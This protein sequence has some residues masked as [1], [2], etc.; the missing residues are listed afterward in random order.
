MDVLGHL[1]NAEGVRAQVSLKRGGGRSTALK[2]SANRSQ[3]R[4]ASALSGKLKHIR[5]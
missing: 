3:L 1:Q 4:K 2:K 5:R